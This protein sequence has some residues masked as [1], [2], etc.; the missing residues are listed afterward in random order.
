MAIHN[1]QP[2]QIDGITYDL[3]GV[4]LAMSTTPRDGRMALSI[5]VT[6]TP[7][8]DGT[9]GPELL[10]EGQTALVYGDAGQA[11]ASDPRLAQFLGALEAAGQTFINARI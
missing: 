10:T 1:P 7:Y 6:L 11:A 2:P 4:A 3:L 5:A 9:D 8:R